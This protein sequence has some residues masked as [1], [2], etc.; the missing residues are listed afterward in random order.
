M[1]DFV[2]IGKKITK[3][4]RSLDWSQEDLANKLYVTRQCVSKWELGNSVP[5]IEVLIDMSKMFFVSID[6]ILCL[7]EQ[8]NIDKENI[9]IGHDRTFI[10][11]KMIANELD[12]SIPDVFYQLS[13]GERLMVLR[14]IRDGK[15]ICDLEEL[16]PKLT[17]GEKKFLGGSEYE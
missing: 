5:S 11:K 10:I 9:F 3:L 15:T 6:E 7:D 17:T 14:E 16:M 4:R 12:V 8:I 1:I 2:Q 13:P